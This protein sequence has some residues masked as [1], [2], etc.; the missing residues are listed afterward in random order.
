MK[1]SVK[2]TV[3]AFRSVLAKGDD[4]LST[5]ACRQAVRRDAG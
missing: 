2:H 3:D 5:A 4:P 1:I